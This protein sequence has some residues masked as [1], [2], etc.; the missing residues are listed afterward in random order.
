MSYLRFNNI[1][2]PIECS[3]IHLDYSNTASSHVA[4]YPYYQQEEKRAFKKEIFIS[5][6]VTIICTNRSTSQLFVSSSTSLLP[7]YRY[8]HQNHYSFSLLFL[9]YMYITGST[10]GYRRRFHRFVSLPPL[11]TLELGLHEPGVGNH[12]V[13]TPVAAVVEYKTARK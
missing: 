13:E 7:K 6:I 1:F 8:I 12:Q 3:R 5:F 2:S 11:S 10:R 9:H 4:T